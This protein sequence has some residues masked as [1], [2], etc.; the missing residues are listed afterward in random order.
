MTRANAPDTEAFEAALE[1]C[2]SE[3]IHH[4]GTIQPQG[5]AMVLAADAPH[6]VLQVSANLLEVTGL[7]GP[8]LLGS[9]LAD[10]LGEH[11]ATVV[12]GLME[13]ASL[14][15]RAIGRLCHRGTDHIPGC[16]VHLYAAGPAFVLEFERI[17]GSGAH[18]GPVDTLLSLQ[19]TALL[20][21]TALD[22]VAYLAEVVGLVG[23]ITGYHSVMA[24]RFDRDW[25]GQ[26]ICQAHRDDTPSYVGIHFPASDIPSQA[27]RLY[28]INPVR[29]VADIDDPRVPLIPPLSPHTGEPL[30]MSYAA[31]RSLSPIHMEYLRNMGVRASMS[32]S[33]MQGDRLWGLIACHHREPK[34]ISII[35]RE[36][37]I[38]ISQLASARLSA[39]EARERHD[40][41]D[42]AMLLHTRLAR[43]LATESVGRIVDA[44][45]PDLQRMLH[46]TGVV[47]ILG[48]RRYCLGEVPEDADLEAMLA[49][50]NASQPGRVLA[51]D[52]LAAVYPPA[53]RF[54]D[55]AAG[56]LASTPTAG[57]A[58]RILW[59]RVEKTRSV[60]WG[61]R[62]EEGLVTNA[63]GDCRL[64]PRK[65]FEIWSETWRGRCEPWTPFEIGFVETLGQA[66]IPE[67]L[68]HKQRLEQAETELRQH[69]YH[70]EELVTAR[71]AELEKA[72]A[73]AEAA[74]VAKTAFLANMSHEIRTPLTAILGVTDLMRR[75]GVD[76]QQDRHLGK[77]E[78][79]GQH[80]LE[81]IN[82]ILDLSKIEA[83]KF[84]LESGPVDV[85]RLVAS[86]AAMLTG[87]AGE[88]GLALRSEVLGV[89]GSLLGDATRLQQALLNYGNNAVKFT[90]SGS[91]TLRVAALEAETDSVLLRFEVED[92]GIGIAPDAVAR[93][94][95]AFE[96]ADNSIS[97]QHGGTG[98]GLAI[99]RK[100]AQMMDGDAGVI[101]EPGVG[102][103]FWF[104]ARLRRGGE[105]PAAS[106]WRVQ[107]LPAESALA[108]AYA[109]RRL[110]LVED[111]LVNREIALTLLADVG[112]AAEVAG[113]GVEALEWVQRTPFDL[114]L[115]DMQMPVMDGLEATRRI[116][117]LPG[118]QQIPIVAMTANA[119]AEDKARCFEAGMNDFL[120]KP[121]H[122]TEF[123]EALVRNLEAN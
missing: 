34:A 56:L 120:G 72:K 118:C 65:S 103:T 6:Q 89:E 62:Y 85:A 8:S 108:Q 104:T 40:L 94:F 2:A 117:A 54:A 5:A 113:N 106:P 32:I 58:D 60:T 100:L 121:F 109:D 25:N 46:A 73:A 123:F 81:V 92:T 67:G 97:R 96:Q 20:S 14:H 112:I 122:P 76:D 77:V 111:D 18:A 13:S 57:G 84:T 16:I 44:L 98:L 55:K 71:T 86:A 53:A 36:A 50:V 78:V 42:Q 119:F 38:F 102:S 114:I 83:G 45:L 27:R 52:H 115:M 95:N 61:G 49:W 69:R 88:K 79:A 17:C 51:I 63:A 1:A 4:I 39:I 21:D 87:R 99:T 105:A 43:S 28:G 37:A 107:V 47:M 24:Y 22:T 15:H 93:L 3:P 66:A 70:L 90:D 31:L 30:D 116:R 11:E 19:Q 82:A 10:V 35:D 80:L 9:A 26:V 74:N 91:V 64:T 33:L 75:A 59:L 101:S 23:R 110:L 41:T 48:E 7:D 29:V 12:R 68:A